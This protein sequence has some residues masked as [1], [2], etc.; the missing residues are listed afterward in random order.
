MKKTVLVLLT[1]ALL[2][3]AVF[4]EK[5]FEVDF[6]DYGVVPG[7]AGDK[8]VY[9]FKDG[10][11]QLRMFPGVN[12]KGN[13]LNLANSEC[14][15]YLMPKNFNPKGGTVSLW[16]SPVNWKLSDP[17]WQVFFFAWQKD[18]EL[19]IHKLAAHYIKATIVHRPAG[20]A[21][22]AITVQARCDAK[23]WSA[24]R[25]HKIDVTWDNENIR[26]Y[27]DG[28][29]PPKTPISVGKSGRVGPTRP[30]GT[31]KIK[32]DLPQ[33]AGRFC[34]GTRH[35]WQ[36]RKQ[37]NREHKT[38]IDSLTIHDRILSA[39]EIQ[40]EYE[41]IIPP[42]VRKR[43]LN[44]AEIPM[45]KGSAPD[46]S[47]ALKLPIAT[48]LRPVELLR[49]D[50]L[51][52]HNGETLFLKYLIYNTAQKTDIT[53]RDGNLWEDDSIEF[54]FASG[55]GKQQNQYIVNS[56][57]VYFDSR[58]LNSKW[59]GN[60]KITAGQ[61]KD[62]WT[63]EMAIPLDDLGGKEL[64]GKELMAAFCVSIQKGRQQNYYH[65][66]TATGTTYKARDIIKL[67][68]DDS[69]YQ[70]DID[71]I[72]L[73]TGN[74]DISGKGN[75]KTENISA[76]IT[77]EGYPEEFY[78]GNF[79][80]VTW[81]RRLAAGKHNLTVKS[82]RFRYYYDFEVDYPLEVS[83][84][85]DPDTGVLS[86]D[87]D[88]VNAGET[89]HNILR[90][91]TI[92]G[93]VKL[94]DPSGK[95]VCESTFTMSA[96]K[97]TAAISLPKDPAAGTYQVAVSTS[98]DHTSFTRNVPFRVPD[99]TPFKLRLGKDHTVPD[100]WQPLKSLGNDRY[101]TLTGTIQ[102]GPGAFPAQLTNKGV[103]L[104]T[105]SP[106][107]MLNGK[108]VKWEKFKREEIFDD[109]AV[110]T[111]TGDA[112]NVKIDWRGE[113]WFD[114]AWI[115]NFKLIPV[116]KN[117]RLD[118]FNIS[119]Q[120]APEAGKFAMDPIYVP[121]KDGKVAVALGGDD[122][123]KDN[124]LWISGHE[125]GVFFWVK[126]N[127]NWVNNRDE[128]PLTARKD[129]SGTS[130]Q[131]NVISRP[132][133][134]PRPA[135]Y[136]MVF[137]GTPSRTP[138]KEF[139]LAN[140]GSMRNSNLTYHSINW[141]GFYNTA[142][143]TDMTTL[144]SCVPAYPEKLRNG[145]GIK[146]KLARNI[147]THIYSMPGQISNLEPA[148][149][150]IGK[151]NWSTPRLNHSGTKL[152]QR[153]ILDYFCFNATDR[154]SDWWCYN[155]DKTLRDFPKIIDGPYFDVAA[156]KFCENRIHGCGGKDVFGQ[157]Y[158]SSDALGLR[159]F[160][161]RVYK[162]VH[163]YNGSVMLH[164]H[165]QF[166][167]MSHGFIDMFAPGEN[168]F[169]VLIKNFEHGYCEEI[170]P[171]QYQV[172]FNW[173]KAGVPYCHI[174]QYGRICRNVPA[175]KKL[176][177]KVENYP[178]YALRALTP[179]ILHDFNTWSTFVYNPTVNH[180]WG[181]RKK[182]GL[183]GD[184][185][186]TGYWE[187]KAVKPLDDKTYCSYYV[188]NT[189]GAPYRRLLLFGNFNRTPVKAACKIDFNALGIE[190]PVTVTE[191]WRNKTKKG[192][193]NWTDHEIPLEAINDITIPGNHFAII[194]I[195]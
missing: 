191:I 49:A 4:A 124:I 3:A 172:D 121:F 109:Y 165:V 25:W 23:E 178:E 162:T 18:F 77:Q 146:S 81:K 73:K 154:T 32:P 65:W 139:R 147:K 108:A 136:T 150:Y 122:R 71:P 126:S 42:P 182:L 22:Q 17:E 5:L 36:K 61:K 10:D 187:N 135:E 166:L 118:S 101:Q 161:M 90:S 194:G 8:R 137:M 93:K 181:L 160:L 57:G 115:V 152:G 12:G 174:I 148:Y 24:G 100:P 44:Y 41:K 59:N 84:N 67:A 175:F 117:A 45:Q 143:P 38:A 110:Y 104:L 54:H 112:G 105:K 58:N 145:E 1:A 79:R 63:V 159:T 193:R 75:L 34:I 35:D 133:T 68:T 16:V 86:L 37:V 26:L 83:V 19:R 69:Y 127:A 48:Q 176:R 180:W 7:I 168:T 50:V 164:S 92:P 95:I 169:H 114:G 43:I 46:W 14:V 179:P 186:F 97:G 103:E 107:W 157:D 87:L 11:L 85:C 155:L 13:S 40:Q 33:A 163:K 173:K 185:D 138:M 140:Y 128:K 156:T 89:T 15:E 96:V 66:G 28:K 55:D 21:M 125:K 184:A 31:F 177:N 52:A 170:P 94:L 183:G 167:P 29:V 151:N 62:F 158:I 141:S 195:K 144:T 106:I 120:V 134:L 80:D 98:G 111:G 9:R 188:I 189:P 113:L 82:D 171:E 190:K 27:I 39:K 192:V 99:M 88:L 20:S 130:V 78:P 132:V 53:V 102:L 64:I 60:A 119:Y 76:K 153:W 131:L 56:R 149:D 30:A 51:A 123:R 129:A 74:M 2:P 70:L 6:D 91:K 116:D 47:K 72:Q 142:S